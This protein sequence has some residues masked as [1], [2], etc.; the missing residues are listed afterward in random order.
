VRSSGIKLIQKLIR[1]I[2][3]S[4]SL[5]YT[6]TSPMNRPS[7]VIGLLTLLVVSALGCQIAF[8]LDVVQDYTDSAA[9]IALI[10]YFN[11]SNIPLTLGIVANKFGLDPTMLSAVQNIMNYDRIEIA[12]NG[13]N[14]ELFT[15]YSIP[16]QVVL[17]EDSRAQIQTTLP[18][19]SVVS[20]IAP[21]DIADNTTFLAVQQA[22]YTILTANP[23]DLSCPVLIAGSEPSYALPDS[24]GVEQPDVQIQLSQCG[25]SIIRL[26]PVN[27][28]LP[29]NQVDTTSMSNLGL[30]F[31][32]LTNFNCTYQLL[33]DLVPST[34]T[35]TSPPT[36]TSPITSTS[37]PTTS[38]VT[39][40]QTQ[41][42]TISPT[43]SPTPSETTTIPHVTTTS[44]ITTLSVTPISSTSPDATTTRPSVPPTSPS[45]TTTNPGATT[46]SPNA[47]TTSLAE[48]MSIQM[49]P[50]IALTSFILMY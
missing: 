33:R 22:G 27:Y 36:S 3:P 7:S 24:G 12:S 47:T 14:Y 43:S 8:R 25:F 34:T 35:S 32:Q 37:P 19:V 49:M 39:Q 46:I 28:A 26:Q 4:F 10:N 31:Q 41:T 23:T 2:H 17:L 15:N 30:L 42:Q 20:F 6:N 50:I 1:P 48:R 9:Q 44:Q 5:N 45:V 21:Q 40:T 11:Q 29:G 18:G 16:E 13:W 38:S